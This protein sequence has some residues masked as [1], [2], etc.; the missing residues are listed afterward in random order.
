MSETDNRIVMFVDLLG[1]ALLTEAFPL[2]VASSVRSND[3]SQ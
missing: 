2:R 3:L 1:F